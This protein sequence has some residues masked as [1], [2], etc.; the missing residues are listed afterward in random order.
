MIDKNTHQKTEVRG[1]FEFGNAGGIEDADF[2]KGS[3]LLYEIQGSPVSHQ[4][5]GNESDD[6]RFLQSRRTGFGNQPD[7]IDGFTKAAIRQRN[8]LAFKESGLRTY[9]WG[10]VIGFD[11]YRLSDKYESIRPGSDR[12][13]HVF[14]IRVEVWQDKAC[15]L[16][17]SQEFVGNFGM[18]IKR[19]LRERWGITKSGQFIPIRF[20][21]RTGNWMADTSKY[22]TAI[23]SPNAKP[24][25]H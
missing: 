18:Q 22:P 5:L 25:L 1:A 2:T 13:K 21:H 17:F 15:Q 10:R 20:S 12:D 6:Y 7:F 19:L 16:E 8:R 14:F 4:K 3:K 9:C 24:P 11:N 23:H